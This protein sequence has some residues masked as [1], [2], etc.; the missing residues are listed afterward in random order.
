MHIHK[1]IY[2]L[3]TYS[4]IYIY[5]YTYIYIYIYI[6]NILQPASPNNVRNSYIMAPHIT[7]HTNYTQ[8]TTHTKYTPF[9]QHTQKLQTQIFV[10][11]H[12]PRNP[13]P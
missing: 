10:S 8:F 2:I 7:I 4:Y 13:P 11:W 9:L 3:Y 12:T 5:I 1:Y 6:Y